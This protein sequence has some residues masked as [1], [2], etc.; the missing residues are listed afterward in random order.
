MSN[1]A[2]SFLRQTPTDPRRAFEQAA[3]FHA[4][5]RLGEAER[6][7]AVVLAADGRHFESIY[8]L[9]LIRLHQGRFA[10]AETLFR[11]AVKLDKRSADAQHYLAVALTGLQRLD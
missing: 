1:G 8:R 11:R 10:D 6:L 4:Q 2:G 9:G 7:Y 5:G 3:A